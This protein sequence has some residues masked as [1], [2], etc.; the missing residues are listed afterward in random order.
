MISMLPR[1]RRRLAL[2]S[3]FT[4]IAAAFVSMPLFA[5]TQKP[6]ILVLVLDQ[7]RADQLHCYGNP[8][9]TSPHIDM[10]A[11][12]GVMFTRFNTVA[13]WTSPSFASLHTSLFPSRHGVTLFWKPGMPLLN[14][15][16]PTLAENMQKA[17]Y[18]TTA[19]VNNSLAGY[20]LTGSGFDEYYE[21]SESA[22]DIT[23]RSS[24]P[25][26]EDVPATTT[27]QV[28]RWLDS[29][30]G[31]KQPFFL[32]VHFLEPHSPYNPP[33]QDD[34]FKSG[35]YSFMTDTGYDFIKGALLRLAANGD[36][37]AIQRL[38]QLYD[39]KIHHIDRYVGAILNHL[40]ELGLDQNIYILLTSDH[41]ELLYSHP[42]DYLTFDHRSLYDA[43]L[44]VPL[45]VAGPGLPKGKSIEALASNIDTAPTIL[46]LAGARPLSDAEGHSLVPLIQGKVASVNNYLYAGEDD[47]IPVREVRDVR[48][49]L[50]RNLWTGKEQLFD[51]QT[52]PGELHN[53]AADNPQEVHALDPRLDDW[54]KVNEPT[55]EVQRERWKIYTQPEKTL[56]VDDVTIGARFLISPC[57]DW[58]S[59]ESPASGNYDGSSFW[60]ENGNGSR[61]AIWRG[62][63]PL[64]GSYDISVYVG[65][66][67]VGMLATNAPYKVVTAEGSKTV[68]L[69]LKDSPG[70]WKSLGTFKDPRY[71]ELTNDA[72]GIVVADAVKFDRVE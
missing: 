27:N 35:P 51:M 24:G 66:P 40:K 47:E 25:A 21:R 59:D 48:Y 1:R 9:E 29:H 3:T 44:H 2:G 28:L 31:G 65:Q 60:T 20:P 8:R 14:K 37:N 18:Y 61:K 19:F 23:R 45:I 6:N 69:N 49:K 7:L 16:I 68:T 43:D 46:D 4:L 11:G 57:S 34:I 32:Y 13:P 33:S 58:H 53:V 70:T 38:Y 12:S 56:T 26:G 64:L 22:P 63:N 55:P 71:V 15:D 42:K 17:G 36:Q 62:D 72:N 5:Q 54:M 50:I 10:L 41:G 39:G 30:H 52:D 67:K